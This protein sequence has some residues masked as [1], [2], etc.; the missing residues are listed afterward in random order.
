ME[1]E[2]AA[3]GAAADD[4]GGAVCGEVFWEEV[5]VLE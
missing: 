3:V 1:G 5:C 4:G 2:S